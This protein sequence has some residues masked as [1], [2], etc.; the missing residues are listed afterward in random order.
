M[1]FTPS[2]VTR[3]S[4]S[5]NLLNIATPEDSWMWDCDASAYGGSMVIFVTHTSRSLLMPSNTMYILDVAKQTWKQGPSIPGVPGLGRES[6][7]CAVSGDH[8][9]VWGGVQGAT[10]ADTTRVFNIKTNE[11][12][13]IYT[14]HTGLQ[15][16]TLF[17]KG[18]QGSIQQSAG[19]DG[20]PRGTGRIKMADSYRVY[21]LLD[22][23]FGLQGAI[24]IRIPLQHPHTIVDM[25]E[26]AFQTPPQH[27]HTIGDQELGNQ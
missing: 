27:P 22:A 4:D 15:T 13:S 6:S 10:Y 11:W 3:S 16:K 17:D 9:I 8:F 2:N 26:L 20:P 7:S 12:V 1:T 5:W 21:S 23:S 14:P 18:C 19:V 24:D 25:N